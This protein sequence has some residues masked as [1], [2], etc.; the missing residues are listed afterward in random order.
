[1]FSDIKVFFEEFL[2]MSR[3][4]KK[5]KKNILVGLESPRI[6]QFKGRKKK[7]PK[8]FLL[9][10]FLKK[11]FCEKILELWKLFLIN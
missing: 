1:M 5:L 2:F 7:G 11:S 6:G 3:F 4:G 10:L 8:D 9:K